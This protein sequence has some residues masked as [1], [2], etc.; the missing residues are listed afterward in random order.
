MTRELSHLPWIADV[1]PYVKG[2]PITAT[3]LSTKPN[4]DFSEEVIRPTYEDAFTL[5]Y[6]QLYS[7]I[8]DGAAVKTTPED[9]KSSA[10]SFSNDTA[11]QDLVI[12]RMVM[13]ALK[14]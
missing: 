11:K 3:V 5:E 6:K 4:G 7:A 8:V 2:L 1:R 10:R 9:G 12:F 14:P 13:D